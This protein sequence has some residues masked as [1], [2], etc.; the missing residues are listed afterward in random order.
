MKMFDRYPEFRWLSGISPDQLGKSC[1]A[2]FIKFVQ[3]A[4]GNH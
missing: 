1:P 4:I 3:L 2:S